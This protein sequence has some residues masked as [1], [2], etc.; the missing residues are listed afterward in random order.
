MQTIKDMTNI[1]EIWKDIPGYKGLYQVSS[2][3]NIKNRFKVKK[4]SIDRYGYP[5]LKLSKDAHKLHFTVHRLVA[6]T[7]ISNPYNKPQVNHIDGNK[8]NNNISNLEWCSN[9]ENAIHAF[10]L[11]LRKSSW[12]GNGS[13][14]GRFGADHNQ[15]KAVNQLTID[16]VFIK[17]YNFIRET[18]KDGFTPTHVGAC[19]A[20]KVKHHRNFKWEFAE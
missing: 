5:C 13:M 6:I 2:F 3:G 17:R 4:Q 16:G 7:F 8:L 11:G 9:S 15:S 12:I 20:G 19:C 1:E 14:K 10:K 18:R